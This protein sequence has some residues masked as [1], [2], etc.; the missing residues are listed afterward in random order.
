M[1]RILTTFCALILAI[2]V[3]AQQS[4]QTLIKVQYNF[5]HVQD[6]TER[7]KPYTETMMLLAGKEASVYTSFDRIEQGVIIN[8]KWMEERKNGIFNS[9]STGLK[10]VSF[11]YFYLFP[12]QHK[13]INYEQTRALNYLVE[14]EI[15]KIDWKIL[16]DTLNFS[17]LRAQKATTTYKGRNW[18]AWFAPELPFTTGPWKLNG[19]P[20]L[21]IEAYDDK[22]D[23]QFKFAG[24]EKVKPGD[25]AVDKARELPEN[26][27]KGN[28][29]LNISEFTV[30]ADKSINRNGPV[31]ITKAEFDKLKAEEAK[32]PVGFLTAQYAAMG[33]KDPAA[34][35][36]AVVSGSGGGGGSANS[37]GAAN[38]QMNEKVPVPVKNPFNN[39]I[40]L[41]QKK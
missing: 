24:V 30:M 14:G 29:D 34:A 36:Q 12:Q 40:E 22:K 27:I 4:Y 20:G 25:L 19:L 32:D 41:S 15:E 11:G 5:I 26:M 2:T 1:K 8:L 35:A 37:S 38:P 17:G 6:T 13:F 23:V 21:I 39:P 18:I 28:R 16:K 9:T 10:S 3:Y 33:R 31:K 7:D